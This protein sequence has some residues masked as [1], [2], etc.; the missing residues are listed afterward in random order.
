MSPLLPAPD[1]APDP[2]TST[3]EFTHQLLEH[4]LG[5]PVSLTRLWWRRTCTADPARDHERIE[6]P[7]G[8]PV[9]EGF[10]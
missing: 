9:P 4:G 6:P 7:G 10:P 2:C 8:R 3:G 5:V 1:P